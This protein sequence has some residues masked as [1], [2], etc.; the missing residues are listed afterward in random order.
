[1]FINLPYKECSKQLDKSVIHLLLHTVFLLTGE[2]ITEP[3]LEEYLMT[4]LGC[5]DN[6]EVEGSFTQSPEVAL[7]D[8]PD[9]ISAAHFAEELLGLST[10]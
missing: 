8:L 6:P 10:Q 4:L 1:M 5:S 3:E 7:Q 2:H 9:K